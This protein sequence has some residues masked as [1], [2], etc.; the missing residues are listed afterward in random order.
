MKPRH[1]AIAAILGTSCTVTGL[2]VSIIAHMLASGRHLAL[3]AEQFHIA[4]SIAEALFGIGGFILF[5]G[6]VYP[7]AL[8]I[9]FPWL[10]KISRRDLAAQKN[11]LLFRIFYIKKGNK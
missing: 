6:A 9:S 5:F 2:G 3:N 11:S 7:I 8:T 4:D 10:S 1:V